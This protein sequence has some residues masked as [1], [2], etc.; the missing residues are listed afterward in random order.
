M[1]R[2]LDSPLD[3]NPAGNYAHFMVTEM[4]PEY[5][6]TLRRMTGQQKLRTAFVLYHSARKLKSCALRRS[7]PELSETQIQQMVKHIFLH[8]SS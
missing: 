8:A 7:H 6:A 4:T 3:G 5:R 1:I 2:R